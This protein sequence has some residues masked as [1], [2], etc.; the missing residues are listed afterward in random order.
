MG[1]PPGRQANYATVTGQLWTPSAPARERRP[2]TRAE[3]ALHDMKD[4]CWVNIAGKV[5]D[6]TAWVP[7]HSCGAGV[8]RTYAGKEA[9]AEFGDKQRRSC[10]AHGPFL[11]R[12]ARRGSSR[13]ADGRA[14]KQIGA[15]PGNSVAAEEFLLQAYLSQPCPGDSGS[16][17]SRDA[18]GV[19]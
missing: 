1:F 6:I 15:P 10:R 18:Q 11:H 12:R 9:T 2:V 5:Y 3:V 13:L 7:R 16:R 17:A 19:Q 4:D 14:D 8:A